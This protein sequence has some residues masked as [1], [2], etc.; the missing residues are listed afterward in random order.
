MSELKPSDALALRALY[1]GLSWRANL[2]VESRAR[3]REMDW[4]IAGPRG[5]GQTYSELPGSTAWN[6]FRSRMASGAG[7]RKI[8]IMHSFKRG[9]RVL[10]HRGDHAEPAIVTIA[11]RNGRSLAVEALNEKLPYSGFAVDRRTGRMVLLLLQ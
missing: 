6:S 2:G 3:A 10:V 11:S 4:S 9:D 8:N 5:V 7:K 1:P